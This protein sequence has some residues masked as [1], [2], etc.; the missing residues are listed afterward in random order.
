MTL[1][2]N[3]YQQQKSIYKLALGDPKYIQFTDISALG[4]GGVWT[5]GTHHLTPIVWSILFPSEVRNL[6]VSEKNK[7]GYITNSDLELT[8]LLLGWI[9]LESIMPNLQHCHIGMFCNNT[10]TITWSNSL[11]SKQ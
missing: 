7:K 5:S 3:I 1:R 4:A 9:V 6:L 11:M 8:G 2:S 10:P